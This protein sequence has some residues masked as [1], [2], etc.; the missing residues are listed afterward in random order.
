MEYSVTKLA[1]NKD[2][3]VEDILNKDFKGDMSSC[4][5][6]L[7]IAQGYLNLMLLSKVTGAGVD[8]LDKIHHYARAS[9]KENPN[10]YIFIHE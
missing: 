8:A 3:F 6:E 1:L 9:N 2:A 7:G 4:A 5:A 10:K